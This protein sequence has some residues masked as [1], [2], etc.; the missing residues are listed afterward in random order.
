MAITKLI[1]GGFKSLRDPVEIPL[2][3][4]TLMFGPNSAG[5][6]SVKD[7]LVELRAR[8]DRGSEEESSSARFIGLIRGDDFAHELQREDETDERSTTNVLLGSEHD[9][10]ATEGSAELSSS[11]RWGDLGCEF[12]YELANRVVRYQFVDLVAAY[13]IAYRLEVDEAMPL[14]YS[15]LPPPDTGAS[16][17]IPPIDERF[18]LRDRQTGWLQLNLDH[19]LWHQKDRAALVTELLHAAS[20]SEGEWAGSAIWRDGSALVIRT[21]A[22]LR[23]LYGWAGPADPWGAPK[24]LSD[25]VQRIDVA[26]TRLCLMVNELVHQTEWAIAGQLDLALVPGTRQVLKEEDV[27]SGWIP[28]NSGPL[29]RF[30]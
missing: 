6:S 11:T 15:E 5:K 17:A 28:I 12:F 3:P 30:P 21:G 8:L 19:P 26:L 18:P 13:T 10:L 16:G 4:I 2:A 20:L 22:S 25:E 1:V 29:L 7:A 9:G 23:R 24:Q 14:D 27:C